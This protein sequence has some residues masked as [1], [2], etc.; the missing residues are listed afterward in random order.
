MSERRRAELGGVLP[1]VVLIGSLALIAAGSFLLY[2]APGAPDPTQA[3]DRPQRRAPAF[4]LRDLNGGTRTL[5]QFLVDRP[6]LLEFMDPTCPHCAQMAPVL[7]RLHAAYGA[8][9]GFSRSRSKGATTPAGSGGSPSSTR[10]PGHIS[11]ET[12]MWPA[13]TGCC[14]G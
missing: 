3:A 6:L 4:S 1:I 7:T 2:P 12:T 5:G 8:G 14:S 13:R 9:S 11:W 10:I